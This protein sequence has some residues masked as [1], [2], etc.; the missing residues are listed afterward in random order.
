MQVIN[1]LDQDSRAWSYIMTYKLI[2]FFHGP[3]MPSSKPKMSQLQSKEVKLQ[4]THVNQHIDNVSTSSL[5]VINNI[6]STNP[7]AHNSS[8][9]LKWNTTEFVN[10]KLTA[11]FAMFT[12]NWNSLLESRFWI[13]GEFF[14]VYTTQTICDHI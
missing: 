14:S 1:K 12:C 10:Q 11:M 13:F 7:I 4:N 9:E 3:P 2:Y 8:T 6:T 5:D